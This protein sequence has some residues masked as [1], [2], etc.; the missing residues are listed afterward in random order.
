[1]S[2]GSAAE[3]FL[4]TRLAAEHGTRYEEPARIWDAREP[5][6]VERAEPC[7]GSSAGIRGC[8][9]SIEGR[10]GLRLA[11]R[12]AISNRQSHLARRAR[13]HGPYHYV[14]HAPAVS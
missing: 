3:G 7:M 10:A 4:F 6:P 8:A 12:R 2:A 11:A 9:L 14:R 1:C 5:D 13:G